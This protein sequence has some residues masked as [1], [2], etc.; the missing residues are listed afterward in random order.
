MDLRA[1]PRLVSESE[2]AEVLLDKPIVLIGRHHECD[3]QLNSRKVS[4]RHCCIAQVNDKL[5]VRDL[6]STNG[7]L[8]NG[9]LVTRTV[10]EPGD[11]LAIGN[12]TFRVVWDSPNGSAGS[13]KSE[14]EESP[15]VA[16][17]ESISS[18]DPEV[19]QDIPVPLPD[20]HSESNQ[21][22][23]IENSALKRKIESLPDQPASL[24]LPEDLHSSVD[25]E[26]PGPNL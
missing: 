9:E 16:V 10:L 22:E 17:L 25:D 11:E 14:A 8:V 1:Y 19:S 23:V 4:R 3:V 15:P 13:A 24:V 5:V 20:S 7:V 21:P 12:Y 2:H 26:N 6:C 18:A